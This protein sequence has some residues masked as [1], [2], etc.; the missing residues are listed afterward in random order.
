[1]KRKEEKGKLEV[2]K[3]R[4]CLAM[5]SAFSFLLAAVGAEPTKVYLLFDTEDYTCDR[6]ND[7]IRD[8]ANILTSEGVRGN[9]NIVGYLATRLMEL[10]RF[11][12]IEALR[13]HVIGTQTLYHSRH[14]DLSELGEDPDYGR[15]YRR[16]LA[17][18]A[19]G[20]G[21][22]EAVLGEGRC[23][24]AA[25]PGNSISP[26]SFDVYSDLGIFL[27]LGTGTYGHK[28][29]DG[30]YPRT[31]LTRSDGK[32][33]GLWYFNQV[34]IPYYVSFTIQNDLLPGRYGNIDATLNKLA[35]WD[36]AV[37]YMHPDM[38]V[39][40]MH[41]DQP[42]YKKAN[43]VEWR[44]WRQVPD[45]NPTDTA[46]YYEN[47]RDFIRRLKTDGRFEVSDLE[48]YLRS[49]KPRKVITMSDLPSIHA[50]LR[51][52]FGC[53]HGEA[54]WCVADVFQA[55]VRYLRG[56]APQ[57]PGKAYGFL[58]KPR[59]T[60]TS[61]EV[62]ASDLRTAAEK[63]DLSR[64]LPSEISVGGTKIGPADFLFAALEVLTTGAEK[65]KV[66]PRE[67]LGSFALIDCFEKFTLADTW[68]H[69]PEFKDR[70]VTDRLRLQLWTMRIE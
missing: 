48:V 55:V 24:F 62:L 67:Q 41:W 10:K 70:Y 31:M 19:K 21:M 3:T 20:I 8:V 52:N 28:A 64:F 43:L 17:D 61:V 39:K 49:L 22:L 59:G 44:K 32:V 30:G 6:S 15:S 35:E 33:L 9:F 38:A 56:E 68:M 63:I 42:N 18:E 26:A 40:T 54:S 37:L 1:M 34:Q 57:M 53:L 11:D 4:R 69:T 29:E 51:K 5:L 36:G 25:P 23:C 45:R 2:L 60:E 50:A 14:P 65:V 27:N 12:V 13:P 46:I 47:L 16:T 7:A 58:Q 66:E